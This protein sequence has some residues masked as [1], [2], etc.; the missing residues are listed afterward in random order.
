MPYEAN[1]F[2]IMLS[3]PSDS[4]DARRVATR[5]IDEW[6]H[7]NSY[8]TNTVLLPIQWEMDSVPEIGGHPQA[9]LNQQL[10][11]TSDAVIAIFRMKLGSPTI[12]H[13]SGTAEEIA[14]FSSQG[15]DVLVYFFGGDIPQSAIDDPQYRSLLEF[16]NQLREI[17]LH[18]LYA[19]HD[20]LRSQI[21]SHLARLAHSLRAKSS[22][23]A[24]LDNDIVAA[25]TFWSKSVGAKVQWEGMARQNSSLGRA[26]AFLDE[27]REHLL[28]FL[29]AVHGRELFSAAD[30]TG[31]LVREIES[32]LNEYD[33]EARFNPWQRRRFWISGHSII[34]RSLEISEAVRNNGETEGLLQP[35]LAEQYRESGVLGLEVGRSHG[36]V[37]QEGSAV[38]D[39]NIFNAGSGWLRIERLVWGALTSPFN[40]SLPDTAQF[41]PGWLNLPIKVTVPVA[42][43]VPLLVG[44][45]VEV[46]YSDRSGS[47]LAVFRL[48]EPLE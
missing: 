1:V 47:Y 20:H 5:V 16:R 27:H 7:Q 42:D 39:L 21:Q 6:N 40:I 2:R 4:A 31:T 10:V 22:P 37:E 12:A 33:S 43:Q 35:T 45:E 14:E 3:G 9:L 30:A 25:D 11:N 46:E 13:A 28:T 18:G 15:K 32:L 8:A 29:P 23:N 24:V 48:L 41:G 19:D 36:K 34:L 17:G 38:L 26:L 44:T